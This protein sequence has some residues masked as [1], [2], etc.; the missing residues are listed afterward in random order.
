MNPFFSSLY[1]TLS[2]FYFFISLFIRTALYLSFPL[3]LFLSFCRSLALSLSPS[4][5]I[6]FFSVALFLSLSLSLYFLFSVA[7]FL[8]L[9]PSLF[10]SFFLS[11]SVSRSL[12]LSFFLSLS[13]SLS[14]FLSYYRSL[15]LVF[16]SLYIWASVHSACW[17]V[18]IILLNS[19]HL[20]HNSFNLFSPGFR[21]CLCLLKIILGVWQKSLLFSRN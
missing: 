2:Q 20:P 19:S 16:E 12:F 8:S 13:V 4:L 6:S 18:G 17:L 21:A 11:V 1:I 15:F 9:S 5:F 3:S 14:L 7:L 10:I